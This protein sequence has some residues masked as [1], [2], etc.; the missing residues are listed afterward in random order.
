RQVR[1]AVAGDVSRLKGAA[2]RNFAIIRK[3][4]LLIIQVSASADLLPGI[5]EADAVVDALFGTGLSRAVDGLFADLIRLMN[6]CGKPVISLDI[7]SGVNGDTG[8][9]LGTA[10][11]ALAT[12][13]FGLPKY[14]NLLYPGAS[15]GG[16]LYVSHISFPPGHYGSSGIRAETNEAL[17]LPPRNPAGHKGS[18][19]HAL[20]IAGA[21]GYYGAPLFAAMAML[22]AGGG[23]SRLAAPLRVCEHA[24]MQARELVCHPMEETAEGSLALENADKLLSLSADSDFVVLGPGISLDRETRE[25]VF[26]LAGHIEKPLLLDGDALTALVERPDI[27]AKRKFPTILTP[28]AGEFA[29]L[30]GTDAASVEAD[31]I[32]S[33]CRAL[34]RFG[35]HILLKGAHSLAGMP[36]GSVFI[37]LSGNS[38]M[39]TAG[40]G[41]VLT[42]AVAAMFALFS[43]D[44][45]DRTGKALRN[46]VFV[47]GLAGDIAAER[48]GQDGMTAS[49]ILS[50]LPEAVR[51]LRTGEYG[52]TEPVV[53]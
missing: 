25:L 27:I 24:A 22:R 44:G 2:E 21:A 47:H 50:C 28:H 31:R 20:F 15:N 38:G 43:G 17:T 51:R 33:L 29:R 11:R 7:P 19:G 32:T 12:V 6:G 48:L 26:R 35:C 52:R 46:G 45:E 49:D 16:R 1:V 10:V 9:I 36:D 42:G 18:F 4:N 53:V 40:S 8:Q 13:T 37:N 39:A 5:E 3:M 30:T 14:G 34:E 41:D 23:Y